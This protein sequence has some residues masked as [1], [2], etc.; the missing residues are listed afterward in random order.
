MN[1]TKAELSKMLAK[2]LH[3]DPVEAKKIIETL[4]NIIKREVGQGNDVIIRGFGRFYL[5]WKAA[6]KGRNI[7]KGTFIDI[8]EHFDPEFK[9]YPEFIDQ[10]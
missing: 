4:T 6:K 9:A 2:T 10:R 3:K 1:I 8:P 7:S 5:K